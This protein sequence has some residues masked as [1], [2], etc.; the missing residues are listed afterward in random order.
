LLNLAEI[1]DLKAA[2]LA[3]GAHGWSHVDLTACSSQQR[4]D[5]IG[6]CHE[7][8]AS[9]LGERSPVFCYPWGRFDAAVVAEVRRA[10]F[11][12]AVAGGWGRWHSGADLIALRRIAVDWT[13]TVSDFR[14]KLRGGYG[15]WTAPWWR[16][17][18]DWQAPA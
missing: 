18:R 8:L 17:L 4:A 3:V 11:I 12:A 10:G 7:F 6:Q 1:D 14:W 5:E 16:E 15:W 9:R 13:D 2:G